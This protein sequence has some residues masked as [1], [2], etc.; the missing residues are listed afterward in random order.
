MDTK[1]F[2]IYAPVIIPTLCRFEHFKR[3][4]DSLSRCTGAEYTDLYIG[5]DFPAKDSH[6]PGYNKICGYVSQITGFNQVIV[7]KREYNYGASA[8]T[9]ALKESIIKQ[10]DRYIFSDDDNEFSPNFLDYMNEGLTRF[11]D[12]PNILKICGRER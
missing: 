4:I 12:N 9:H 5:L 6:W 3:C 1:R 7:Y 10:Y 11:K 8:N 2:E